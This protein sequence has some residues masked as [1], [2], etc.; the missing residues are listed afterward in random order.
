MVTPGRFPRRTRIA[1]IGLGYWGP[2]LLRVLGD[3]E[4]VEIA[5]VCDLDA[6]RLKRFTRRHPEERATSD[7]DVVFGDPTVDAVIMEPPT[8]THFAVA[9]RTLAA[10]K[11]T[12]VEK[13]LAASTL[14]P[15]AMLELAHKQG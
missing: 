8:Q 10:G 13:H 5:Y 6:E 7:L 4:D 3:M 12:F 2:N 9:I 15:D 14:S 11:H 1:Q